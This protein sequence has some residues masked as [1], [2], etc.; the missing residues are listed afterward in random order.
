MRSLEAADRAQKEAPEVRW[1]SVGDREADIYELFE[2]AGQLGS[3]FLV[4]S[5]HKRKLSKETKVWDL[6]EEEEPAGRVKVSV[7]G[8]D[9]MGYPFHWPDRRASASCLLPVNKHFVC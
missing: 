8:K 5:F 4:R 7:N 1:V 9:K 2:R 6:G 3:S